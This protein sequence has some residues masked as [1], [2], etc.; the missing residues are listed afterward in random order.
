MN[1]E[2]GSGEDGHAAEVEDQVLVFCIFLIQLFIYPPYDIYLYLSKGPFH[3]L[4]IY[5]IW[6][7]NL[8]VLEGIFETKFQVRFFFPKNFEGISFV[9]FTTFLKNEEILKGFLL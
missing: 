1:P 5:Y 4:N 6:V 7:T 8:S 9:K 2:T 3:S